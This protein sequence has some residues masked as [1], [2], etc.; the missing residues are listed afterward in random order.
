MPKGMSIEAVNWFIVI[1]S[2]R[3]KAISAIQI[4][5]LTRRQILAT[6]SAESRFVIGPLAGT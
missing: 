6:P 3:R 4:T 5:I 1:F 2:W